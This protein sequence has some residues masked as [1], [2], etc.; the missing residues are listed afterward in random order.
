[1]IERKQE[2]LLR[3]REHCAQHGVGLRCSAEGLE[4]S[5]SSLTLLV[6]RAADFRDGL[7]KR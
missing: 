7:L 2:S 6:S 4:R 5:G 1:V 3:S